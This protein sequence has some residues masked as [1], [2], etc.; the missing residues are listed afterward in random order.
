MQKHEEKERATLNRV[1][2]FLSGLPPG[3]IVGDIGKPL[4]ELTGIVT[5]LTTHAAAQDTHTR[6]SKADTAALVTARRTLRVHHMQP[7]ASAAAAILKSPSGYDQALLM[8]KGKVRSPALVTAATAMGAAAQPQ[9][10]LFIQHGLAPDFLAALAA[11]AAAVQAIVTSRAQNVG[12][13]NGA[14]KGVKTALSRGR[15]L[16]KMLNAIV[17]PAIEHNSVLLEAWRTAKGTARAVK[18]VVHVSGTPVAGQPAAGTP[19][20]ASTPQTPSVATTQ[21]PSVASSQ[22]PSVASSQAPSTGATGAAPAHSTSTTSPSTT[23]AATT[24]VSTA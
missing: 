17:T 21:T 2:T 16:V 8:P 20:A 3:T 4:V 14:T 22:A 10:A 15:V 1:T 5:Q 9:A 19:P 13:R 7:I 6:L 12:L 23:A 24:G 11:A 18:P